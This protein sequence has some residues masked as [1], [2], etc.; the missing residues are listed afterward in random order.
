M[1]VEFIEEK[2]ERR[3]FSNW[4]GK[5]IDHIDTFAITDSG[6]WHIRG[7]AIYANTGAPAQEWDQEEIEE[8]KSHFIRSG[9]KWICYYCPSGYLGQNPNWADPFEF[10][11][12]VRKNNYTFR[13]EATKLRYQEPNKDLIYVA[14][15]HGNLVEVSYAFHFRIFDMDTAKKIEETL[16]Q[17][18]RGKEQQKE[19][20]Q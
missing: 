20:E 18:K 10:L 12:F 17:I 4:F 3:H 8:L 11:E 13:E 19:D 14:E 5:E 9:G 1:K 6:R 15:F 7:K 16:N 2:R